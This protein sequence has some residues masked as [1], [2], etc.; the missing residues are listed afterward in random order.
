MASD[1]EVVVVEMG[2][3][4]RAARL[5]ARRSQRAVGKQVGV[6]Q[7][8]ISK[9]ELGRG[10]GVD[11][12]TWLVVAGA[13]GLRLEFGPRST[14]LIA[15]CQRLTV[16]TAESGGWTAIRGS[17]ETIL[18]R[19]GDRVVVR[20]WDPVTSV[21]HEIDRLGASVEQQRAS[22]VR[23][24]GLVVIPATGPNR[25]RVSELRGELRE[26]FPA[27]GNAWFAALVNASRP[28]PD[29]PGILWAFPDADRLRPA[30]VDPGWIWTAVGD[31]PRFATGRRRR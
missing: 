31:G 18:A 16:E 17:D 13:V 6:S 22:G 15:K 20:A 10:S 27:R 28:M 25:R 1:A 5:R 19:A 26:K 9:L 4:L 3:R 21:A 14:E 30:T 23:V 24:S 7:A 11:L 29:E 8:L 2:R 12:A